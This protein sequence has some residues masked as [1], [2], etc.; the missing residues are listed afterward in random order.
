[1]P[2]TGQITG[3]SVMHLELFSHY[4]TLLY[5]QITSLVVGI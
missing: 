5:V 2:N 4:Q 3:G 1:M